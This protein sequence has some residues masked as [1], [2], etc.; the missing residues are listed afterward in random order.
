MIA[1]N[2]NW[3]D[4]LLTKDTAQKWHKKGLLSDEKWQAIEAAYTSNFY[5]PN[6]FVRIGLA[7]FTLILLMAAGGL[8]AVFFEPN[9]EMGLSIFSLFWGVI[10]V[11]VL[12][13]RVIQPGRHY[14]SGIDDMFLYVAIG[15][16][17]T[18]LCSPL[19]YTT[20][21]LVYYCIAWPF[22]VAGSIRYIDRLLAVAAFVCSMGIVL[23]A[24]KEIPRLA[25]YLLPFAGMLFS[26]AVYI[27]SKQGQARYGWRHWNG[28][29]MVAELLALVTFYASGN[30]WVV[31]QAGAD[32]FQ[33][34][35]VPMA[36][37]FWAFTF[38]VPFLYI[39]AGLR[40]KD[41]HLLDIGLGCVAAAV[42][43]FRYYYHVLPLTWA[44]VICGAVLFV[45]AYFSIRYLHQNEGGAYSYEED[46]ET[47]L[48][49]EIEQ[50]LIEQ[51]IVNQP[52][53]TP[54]KTESFGGG[55]FGGGGAGDSF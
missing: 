1:Y 4:A 23:L 41:R 51:T 48:L 28:I 27:F 40:R 10:C 34:E 11:L 2:S 50:Q 35:T 33:L 54:E 30:Y 3:L 18:G 25:L 15:A 16:F 52:G 14:G 6:I 7:I 47:T 5:S 44:T 53:P 29:L 8:V 13:L 31:Q 55:Q 19:D 45:T 26:A 12:E 49:Q 39:F 32:F 9:S 42:F 38:I 46:S 20:P 43:S 17:L 21:T 24:V 37:F 36:W 22:L